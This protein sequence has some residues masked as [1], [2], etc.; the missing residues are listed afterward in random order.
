MINLTRTSE[1]FS[2]STADYVV[3]TDKEY[4]LRDFINEVLLN[5]N[6]WGEFQIGKLRLPYKHGKLMSGMPLEA[7]NLIAE[8]DAHGGWSLMNYYIKLKER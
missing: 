7:S 2:D 3:E 4:L 6:Q 8:V 5:K 1:I